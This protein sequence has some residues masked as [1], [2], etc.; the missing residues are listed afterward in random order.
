MSKR[1]NDNG[2][3]R[4]VCTRMIESKTCDNRRRYYLDDI[5]R[6]VV[7]GLRAELGTR[8]AVA[9]YV[10]CY[11]D[12]RR[13]AAQ[14][15]RDN[16]PDLESQLASIERQLNR[17]VQA[18][19]EERI[20]QEEADQHLPALR[21]RRAE[22]LGELAMRSEPKVI[23]LRP[24][25]VDTYLRDLDRLEEVVNADLAA[26]DEEAAKAIRSLVE[27]VTIMPTPRGN[28]PGIIV[29]GGLQ[30]LLELSPFVNGSHF[31]GASGAGCPLPSRWG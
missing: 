4:I 26:G 8:E 12:E 31:G 29:R 6:F 14:A 25:A 24:A 21:A 22:I 15:S 9:Y 10:R 11:N 16:R 5:E 28:P 18:V 3:P 19:I 1:D 13:R 30:S 23:Q 17:A 7:G 2:R 20:T 27:T